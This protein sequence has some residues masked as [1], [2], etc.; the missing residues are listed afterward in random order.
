MS[1]TAALA[2][3]ERTSAH[4]AGS[5]GRLTHEIKIRE[6]DTGTTLTLLITPGQAADLIQ[7]LNTAKETTR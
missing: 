6:L 1:L 5:H 3:W 4:A 7:R 2:A